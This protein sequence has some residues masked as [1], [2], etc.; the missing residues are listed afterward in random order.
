[1]C[2]LKIHTPCPEK[3]ELMSP[4]SQ[5]AYC[6][7]CEKEVHNMVDARKQEIYQ[8]MKDSNG[9]PCMRLT[10]RM[11]EEIAKDFSEWELQSSKGIS[12]RFYLA[13]VIVFGMSLFSFQ[14]AQQQKIFQNY[15]DSMYQMMAQD[16][17]K[18]G[19]PT[20]TLA[21]EDSL[22]IQALELNW[23]TLVKPEVPETPKVELVQVILGDFIVSGGMGPT[24]QTDPYP[25]TFLPPLALDVNDFLNDQLQKLNVASSKENGFFLP[26]EQVS[27]F[28]PMTT[29]FD[30]E[31]NYS[32]QL[33]NEK[34]QVI[35]RMGSYTGKQGKSVQTIF[36]LGIPVGK[37]LLEMK[38]ETFSTYQ[39]IHVFG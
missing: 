13:F 10:N 14:S 7:S 3:W 36:F 23:D 35:H 21:K 12:S 22:L 24:I 30:R 4:T 2:A 27:F 34:G 18:E 5:G 29:I 19:N 33:I 16:T 17:L 15:Q 39:V 31:E 20:D 6:S 8:L 26:F 37:Y 28:A 1:M 11:N 9:I 25:G 38:A 32:L